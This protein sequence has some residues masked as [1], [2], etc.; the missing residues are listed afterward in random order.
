MRGVVAIQIVAP[1]QG[2]VANVPSQLAPQGSLVDGSNVFV[3]IDGRL[4]VRSGYAQVGVLTPAERVNGLVSYRDS[5]GDFVDVVATVN[6]WQKYNND[7][8]FTDIS[9]GTQLAGDPDDPT[10]FVP[11]QQGGIVW[12]YGVNN[13]NDGLYAWNSGLPAYVQIVGGLVTPILTATESGTTVTV[14]SAANPIGIAIGDSV[15]I[16]G[17]SVSTY[18][19]TWTVTSVPSP[20]TFQYT[21]GSS[22]WSASTG[23]TAQDTS[24]SAG[25]PFA[26][27]RDMTVLANRIVVVNTVEGGTRYGSRVRWSAVNNGQVWPV[28]SFIDMQDNFNDSCVGI[29]R[30]G[31]NSAI[32]YRDLSAWL[33]S[34][35]PGNDANA[36]TT[37]RINVTDNMTGPCGPAAIAIAEGCHYYLGQDGRVYT[38][39]GSSIYPISDPVDPVVRGLLNTDISDRVSATYIPGLRAVQFFFPALTDSDPA[40]GLMYSIRRQ[41]FE[42][43]MTFADPMTTAGVATESFGLTWNNWVF[44]APVGWLTQPSASAV[45]PS[46]YA[47]WSVIPYNNSLSV[48]TG[49]PSG[50]V[51]RFWN[52]TSDNGS[53]ISFFA[54]WPPTSQDPTKVQRVSDVELFL[55][56][57]VTPEELSF[58]IWGLLQ[59]YTEPGTAIMAVTVDLAD[60]DT[61]TI[62]AQPGPANPHNIPANFLQW[63]I[64]GV[65]VLGQMALAG[66]TIFVDVELRSDNYGIQ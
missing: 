14:T 8:T 7:N 1:T 39:D 36:F 3:D 26:A 18:D 37:E 44:P 16:T 56:P 27:A 60:Q 24:P 25:A 34:A 64:D 31:A 30:T 2:L 53:P 45:T 48:W 28:L 13:A 22:G 42:P 10:R 40:H 20:T 5:N 52:T 58:I 35:Y 32:I 6:R 47:S 17:S 50:N 61:Y 33:L 57:A 63:K 59:P 65:G 66:G 4:K 43:I 55:Q 62:P 29:A 23:G 38:F 12:I 15:T 51:Y 46:S 9:G 11:F 54:V 19:G 21:G 41:A 49:D